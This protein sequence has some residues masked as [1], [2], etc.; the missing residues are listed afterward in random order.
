MATFGSGASI[1][2]VA[3]RTTASAKVVLGATMQSTAKFLTVKRRSP[4]S[5]ATPTVSVFSDL[6]PKTLD[7]FSVFDIFRVSSSI[8]FFEVEGIAVRNLFDVIQK[9]Q[10]VGKMK[11][12]DKIRLLRLVLFNFLIGNG[13]AHGK[14]FSVVYRGNSIELAPGYDLLS[15]LVYGNL[16]SDKMV[17]KIGSKYKFK[18]VRPKHV[19]QIGISEKLMKREI[20]SLTAKIR[21]ESEQLQKSLHMYN[22]SM[23]QKIVSV[24]KKQSQLF[25]NF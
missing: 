10:S 23:F 14:N 7:P 9:F 21:E 25:T 2:S 1:F 6:Y 17:M 15:T 5:V 22:T 12:V 24:I 19:L 20:P 3:I 11:G 4:H 13:D 8:V 16:R 18:A